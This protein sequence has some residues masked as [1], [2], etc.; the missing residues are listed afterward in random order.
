MK[1]AQYKVDAYYDMIFSAL[2]TSTIESFSFNT[3]VDQL[4]IPCAVLLGMG[5]VLFDVNNLMQR[6][7]FLLF[8]HI[9][10]ELQMHIRLSLFY[11]IFLF[12]FY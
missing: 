7:Y 9:K 11:R 10:T 3:L 12:Y 4:I 8:L 6:L 1:Y 5:I 2:A